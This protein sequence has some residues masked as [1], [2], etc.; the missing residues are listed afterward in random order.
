[1]DTAAVDAE[2]NV[3]QNADE[4]WRPNIRCVVIDCSSMSFIDYAGMMTLQQVSA[5]TITALFI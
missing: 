1:V 5:I 3:E 2:D 4:T